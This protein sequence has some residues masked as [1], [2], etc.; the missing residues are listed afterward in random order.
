MLS[1]KFSSVTFS[2]AIFSL[3]GGAD[4]EPCCSERLKNRSTSSAIK[5]FIKI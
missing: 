3:T 5:R 4:L 2:S 1:S